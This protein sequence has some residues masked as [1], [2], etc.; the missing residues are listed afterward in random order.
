MSTVLCPASR[1]FDDLLIDETLNDSFEDSL[2]TPIG[3]GADPGTSSAASD[4]SRFGPSTPYSEKRRGG[5]LK[6]PTDPDEIS[7][8]S[9]VEYNTRRTGSAHSDRNRGAG[10]AGG[11]G[12]VGG[13]IVRNGNG[14]TTRED[15][16]DAAAVATVGVDV[17][18]RNYVEGEEDN[19][20]L[21][22]SL[23][24]VTLILHPSDSQVIPCLLFLSLPPV[25]TLSP[26]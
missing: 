20:L 16:M 7:T 5:L 13:H 9:G 19:D 3:A 25:L 26:R 18:E 14:T 17:A 4:L 11:G 24:P 12:S 10:T 23:I 8:T 6:N 2:V 1:Q 15:K 22:I 21:P